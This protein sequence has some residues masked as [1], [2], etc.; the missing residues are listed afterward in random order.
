MNNPTTN[1]NQAHP[2]SSNAEGLVALTDR[3]HSSSSANTPN[4]SSDGQNVA[5]NVNIASP[6][7]KDSNHTIYSEPSGLSDPGKN[8][9]FGELH[10]YVG[11]GSL[12]PRLRYFQIMAKQK[13]DQFTSSN[14]LP[15]LS[16]DGVPCFAPYH[17]PF[18]HI[19]SDNLV[20]ADMDCVKNVPRELYATVILIVSPA[21]DAL[22]V[23][24]AILSWDS[25]QCLLNEVSEKNFVS[26]QDSL[27]Q[28][29]NGKAGRKWFMRSEMIETLSD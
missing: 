19:S 7:S 21:G 5:D 24:Q 12:P 2:A 27:A 13:E 25:E 20:E 8:R 14:C 10:A 18:L 1:D 17:A 3:G 16:M 9:C 6:L 15:A 4:Q 23:I 28:L 29:I 11:A 26:Q 22:L